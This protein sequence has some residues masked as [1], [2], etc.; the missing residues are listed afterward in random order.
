MNVLLLAVPIWTAVGLALGGIYFTTL[1]WNI[2]W[3]ASGKLLAMALVLQ[4]VR[5]GAMASALA[6]IAIHRGAVPL[7]AATGG[8]L[9]AR[10]VSVRWARRG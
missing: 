10:V 8:I 5:F 2:R 6:V 7:L 4:L 9:L 1:H 3:F